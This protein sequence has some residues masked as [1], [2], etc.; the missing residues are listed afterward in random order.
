MRRLQKQQ[1]MLCST[2]SRI[3]A[4]WAIVDGHPVQPIP[5]DGLLQAVPVPPGAHTV[6][7]R[8]ES[9]T[10]HVGLAISIATFAGLAALLVSTSRRKLR[11]SAFDASARPRRA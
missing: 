6:E 1:A 4:G 10:L 5:A 7:L 11:S 8:F 2:K 9:T 3:R